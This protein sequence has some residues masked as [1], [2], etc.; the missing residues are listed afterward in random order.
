MN[1]AN[2]GRAIPLK[3]GLDGNQGLDIFATSSPASRLTSC[4]GDPMGAAL[5]TFTP[6][7]SG[8]TY[9]PG[10]QHYHYVWKTEKAWTGTCRM[11]EVRLA[12]QTVHS[13][14]FRLK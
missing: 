10:T 5:A 14:L 2:A 7:N 11:L 4:E 3:F 8:L 6:G 9:D 13:V 1:T 12:D